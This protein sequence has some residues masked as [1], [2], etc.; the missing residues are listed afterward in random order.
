MINGRRRGSC[1]SPL[2]SGSPTTIMRCRFKKASSPRLLSHEPQ[3]TICQFKNQKL[4][5]D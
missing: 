5:Y 1:L 4:K 3:I 2:W